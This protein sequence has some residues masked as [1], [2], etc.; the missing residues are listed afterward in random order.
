ML[1][2]NEISLTLTKNLK[3]QNQTKYINILDHHICKLIEIKKLTI[4]LIKSF[5][6]PV[7]DIIKV[8]F[9][10]SLKKYLKK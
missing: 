10:I 9:T 7:N 3:S 6:M 5:K 8:F 2:N 4:N 1:N